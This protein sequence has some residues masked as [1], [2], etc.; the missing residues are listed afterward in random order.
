MYP[1]CTFC[2]NR[3]LYILIYTSMSMFVVF[4]HELWLIQIFLTCSH[5]YL[6]CQCNVHH[7][8]IIL[9][10]CGKNTDSACC[11]IVCTLQGH[12]TTRTL[13]LIYWKILA[14]FKIA[15]KLILTGNL[16]IHSLNVQT[17]S[18]LQAAQDHAKYSQCISAPDNQSWRRGI[19]SAF[20]LRVCKANDPSVMLVT[21]SLSS[22]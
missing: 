21:F 17:D 3:T 22:F 13:T 14:G 1:S 9:N 15:S 20:Q 7:L 10:K 11:I 19:W 12:W 6:C 5:K 4:V 8:Y 16:T 2:L 18:T